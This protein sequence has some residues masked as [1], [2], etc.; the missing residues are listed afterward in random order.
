MP[1][2]LIRVSEIFGPTIQGEGPLIGQPTVF[3]RTGGCDSRC[4]WCDTWYAVD[5]AHAATWIP[6]SPTAILERVAVLSGGPC[7][8]TLSGG[9]PA[10]QPLEPL[11]RLGKERGYTFALETQ[12]TQV[13]A[14]FTLL[15]WLVISPKPPSSLQPFRPD[16]LQLIL[17]LVKDLVPTVFKFVI[18]DDADY[19]WARSVAARWSQV[20]VFL[21][22]CNPWVQTDA[23]PT[24]LLQKHLLARLEWLVDKVTADRWW[25]ARVLPQLHVLIWGSRRGV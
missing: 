8:I 24:P 19:T 16:R 10:I 5:P 17:D 21:Q 18:A 4:V 23:L 1:H 11:L 6:L 15:D 3:V 7:L 13:R 22:P 2:D 9:N 20:P 25:E 14:W 12:G